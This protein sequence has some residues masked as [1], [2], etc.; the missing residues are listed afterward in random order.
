MTVGAVGANKKKNFE[1]K[2]KTSPADILLNVFRTTVGVEKLD[3]GN[4]RLNFYLAVRLCRAEALFG[5]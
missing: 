1:R 4:V 3:Q 5:R 2:K